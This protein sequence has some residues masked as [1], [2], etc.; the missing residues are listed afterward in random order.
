[1]MR[2]KQFVPASRPELFT[3]AM[4]SAADA[5]SFDLEDAVE[6]GQKGFARQSLV[7]FFAT[8]Q[9]QNTKA[10]VVRINAIDTTHYAADLE[11]VVS[12][13]PLSSMGNW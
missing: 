2:S 11:V 10:I 5:I 8:N 9:T 4:S 3:K 13:V 1:M 6:E 12:S 7:D